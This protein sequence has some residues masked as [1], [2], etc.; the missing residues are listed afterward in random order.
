MLWR[1]I[2]WMSFRRGLA[3]NL[4][5]L[6]QLGR[7]VVCRER[8]IP[9]EP[10]RHCL[11]PREGRAADIRNLDVLLLSHQQYDQ[12]RHG[13]ATHSGERPPKCSSIVHVEARRAINSSARVT[14]TSPTMTESPPVCGSVLH[15]PTI[16]LSA[17]LLQHSS[18]AKTY[19]TRGRCL[20]HTKHDLAV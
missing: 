6:G 14:T 11:I 16:R 5:T 7:A 12:S 3:T 1:R 19:V 20:G 18:Q 9:I 13:H 17:L 4:N 10:V 8:Q 15:D 2:A